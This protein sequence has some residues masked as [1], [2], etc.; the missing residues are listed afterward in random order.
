VTPFSTS[1]SPHRSAV[2]RRHDVMAARRRLERTLPS[3]A[4]RSDATGRYMLCGVSDI[5]L[6]LSIFASSAGY[7]P[8]EIPVDVRV[9]RSFDI[10]LKRQ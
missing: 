9:T 8:V 7:V 3:A 5:G 10:E 1:T 2:A 4:T 6:G